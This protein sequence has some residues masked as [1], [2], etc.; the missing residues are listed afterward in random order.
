MC[1]RYATATANYPFYILLKKQLSLVYV[2]PNG[3][4]T[5]ILVMLGTKN[6]CIDALQDATVSIITQA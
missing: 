6:K 4:S 1:Y 5:K 2:A 3:I